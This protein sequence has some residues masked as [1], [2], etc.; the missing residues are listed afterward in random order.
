MFSFCGNGGRSIRQGGFC[1]DICVADYRGRGRPVA[2][3]DSARHAGSG[4]SVLVADRLQQ[5][6]RFSVRVDG[7]LYL[8]HPG[9]VSADELVSGSAH[10][11]RVYGVV[12]FDQRLVLD[13]ASLMPNGHERMG[14]A[15]VALRPSGG[16]LSSGRPR[17]ALRYLLFVSP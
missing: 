8:A 10:R 5:V 13:P 14:G 2:E 12:S 6:Y 4:N 3:R 16:S 9:T 1:F 7:A 15:R 11:H 17:G